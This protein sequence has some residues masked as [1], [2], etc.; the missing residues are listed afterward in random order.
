M[1]EIR[2][3]TGIDINPTTIDQST[4]DTLVHE[5][6]DSSTTGTINKNKPQV[7]ALLSRVCSKTVALQTAVGDAFRKHGKRSFVLYVLKDLEHIDISVRYTVAQFIAQFCYE[8]EQNQLFVVEEERES[9]SEA[10]LIHQPTILLLDDILIFHIPQTLIKQF[11]K[12]QRQRK[13][14]GSISVDIPFDPPLLPNGSVESCYCNQCQGKHQC[15]KVWM[16]HL[17]ELELWTSSSSNERPVDDTFMTLEMYLQELIIT[18]SSTVAVTEEEPSALLSYPLFLYNDQPCNTPIDPHTS[19]LGVLIKSKCSVINMYYPYQDK[20]IRLK[21][22]F[23]RLKL[24]QDGSTNT[25]MGVLK[26]QELISKDEYFSKRWGKA[27]EFNAFMQKRRE[28]GSITTLPVV[29]WE[30]VFAFDNAIIC[31]RYIDYIQENYTREMNRLQKIIIYNHSYPL[32]MGKLIN[33]VEEEAEKTTNNDIISTAVSAADKSLLRVVPSEIIVNDCKVIATVDLVSKTLSIQ[34]ST[35]SKV[36]EC[37]LGEA[38]FKLNTTT[39]NSCTSIPSTTS[40]LLFLDEASIETLLQKRCLI[41]D[42]IDALSQ[43]C[44]G[45]KQ[46]VLLRLVKEPTAVANTLIAKPSGPIPGL[47]QDASTLLRQGIVH[48]RI[49]RDSKATLDTLLQLG[50]RVVSLC[51][52]R[53]ASIASKT[54]SSISFQHYRMHERMAGQHRCR[55]C[56]DLILENLNQISLLQ[57]KHRKQKKPTTGSTSEEEVHLYRQCTNR[58]IS[59]YLRILDKSE[60]FNRWEGGGGGGVCSGK[61]RDVLLGQVE[62]LGLCPRTW[63]SGYPDAN[64]YQQI[65]KDRKYRR[66]SSNRLKRELVALHQEEKMKGVDR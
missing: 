6:L 64:E 51:N 39:N 11:K 59:G 63:G 43:V 57:L 23:D 41:L 66:Q 42:T 12:Q 44:D 22:E 1:K 38:A 8:H 15:R 2:Q 33:K 60:A 29:E 40:P 56:R 45:G 58:L 62:A 36:Y 25:S 7:Y 46:Y 53:I 3:L 50:T 27:T 49:N 4:I 31:S 24:L 5:L 9:K 18:R 48:A 47:G 13:N 30:D 21:G 52:K 28:T 37:T 26:M 19:I 16:E 54:T 14:R 32:T 61:K 55:E 65:E 35:N 10:V 17:N 34:C 20:K